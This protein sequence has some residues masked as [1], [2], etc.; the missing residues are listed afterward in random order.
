MVLGL[1]TLTATD[2]A[3][4]RCRMLPSVL[5]RTSD[6]PCCPSSDLSVAQGHPARRLA[7]STV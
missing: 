4:Y 6:R 5:T 3:G 1:L 7:S 2:A